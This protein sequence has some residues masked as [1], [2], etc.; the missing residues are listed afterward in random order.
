M[1]TYMKWVLILL[2][3]GLAANFYFAGT[4]DTIVETSNDLDSLKS[5]E[6]KSYYMLEGQL[7]HTILNRYH[8]KQIKLND[9]LSSIIF[10]RYIESIDYGKNYLLESDIKSFEQYRYTLDDRLKD[11][12]VLPF[13][14]MFNVFLFRM[15]DQIIYT[16]TLLSKEFDYTIDEEYLI[17]RKDALWAKSRTELNDIWRKRVKNDALNLKLND[18]EWEEIQKNLKKRYE[19]YSR[20]LT[21][22]NSEDVFQLAMNSFTASVDPHTNYLSPITSDNF[23]I[24]MS[25]SLEGIGAR[26]QVDDGYTKVVEIIPGGPAFKSKKLHPDDRIT[27]VAQGED[28]EFVDVVGWR[29]TDVVQLIRGPKDSVVR[30]LLLKY[31]KGLDSEPVEL[32]LVRDKVKIEDQSAHSSTVNIM[33]NGK[34]SKIGVITI[35][36][37]YIDFEAKN[38]REKN[39]K[40]TSHDVKELLNELIDESVDG[41]IID[42]RNDGGGSLEEAIRVTG[43][44]IEEGP[45]VQVRDMEGKITVDN[46]LDPEIVYDGPLAVLVNRFSASASEIFSGAIQNYGRGIIIGENTFGKGTVQNMINLNRLTSGKGFKL[47]QV[48]L[49]IAKYYRIDGSSTQRMGVIPDIVFPSY[50]D[51]IDFG[52]SSEPNALKW[53]KIESTDYELFSELVSI[54]PELKKLSEQRRETDSEFDYIREDIEEYKKSIKNNFVSLNEDVRRI[55]KEEREEKRFQRE[56]ERRKIKGL[57]LLDKGEIP[58]EDEKINNDPYLIESAHIITDFISLSIG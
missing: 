40:S 29:I 25:L 49:T 22:Y 45:V 10:D 6:P 5:L 46:D 7:V 23:K 9:S 42:L 50:V 58:P 15:R 39:Y 36:K 31:D 57:K 4:T 1:V 34:S 35:P 3:T 30:L 32:I 13:Y 56:N 21:Q 16:D 18:K 54:I 17:N 27:A 26:L 48:K 43:L 44:F 38:K 52:E 53:D 11:G 51:A 47:G 33:H 2:L 8:Y 12:D 24:D 19:N 41:M 28:G 20:I 14:D 37:F 55:K